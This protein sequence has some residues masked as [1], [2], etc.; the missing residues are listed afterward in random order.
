M[1]GRG[2]MDTLYTIDRILFQAD[3]NLKRA[4]SLAESFIDAILTK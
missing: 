4:C 3:K 2:E 1:D